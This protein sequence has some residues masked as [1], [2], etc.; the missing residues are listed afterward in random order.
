MTGRPLI[1]ATL[2][3]KNEK[4]NVGRCLDSIWEWVDE[5][6]VVDTGSTD[7]TVAALRA[8]AKGRRQPG[9]LKIGR[10][11]WQDDFAAARRAADELATGEW[12]LW[13]D[14]DDTVTGMATL[15]G[16]AEASTE[17]VTAFFA[18]YRYAVDADG[19]AISEL[20]RER[21][22]RNNGTRW[23]GR[24]HEHKLITSGAIVKVRPEDAEWVHHRDHAQRTGDRNLRVLNKWLR[25]EPENPRVVQS[26]AM[27]YM[28]QEQHARAA[29]MF[30]RYLDMPGEP[31]D[32]RAQATRH[33]CVML[34]LQN[35]APDAR[36]A[37]LKAL[38][39]H[40][41]W[42][43]THLTLAECAQT[44]GQPREAIVHARTAIGIGQPDTLLI[45]N[46]LQYTAHPRALIGICL[47]QLGQVEDALAMVQE[48][49]QI[50][51]SY[52]LAAQQ[53][54]QLTG[55]LRKHMA[56]S[57]ILPM[58]D[59]L[60]EAGEPLK[61]RQL[62]DL[63]PWYVENDER[64]VRRREELHR[65]IRDRTVRPAVLPE[66]KAADQFVNRHLKEAA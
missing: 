11:K 19:N 36:A 66:D 18:R 32:R 15:R 47:A 49:L 37:A 4:H 3:A 42:A 7:G 8:Y 31:P 35:R 48:A 50:A 51:P 26:I 33:M 25:D 27:E 23:E 17:E 6:C 16:F 20:W 62:L 41:L 63:A 56:I 57:G 34:L 5:V 29:D 61:A 39:E 38:D 14:F 2:I 9:K 10:F 44:M 22:V 21:L 58:V 12:L 24:L 13:L 1:S 55:M 43:D 60:L 46:P 53:L 64:L 52:P 45:I 59:V 28:G 40:W 54:P 65:L 30:A